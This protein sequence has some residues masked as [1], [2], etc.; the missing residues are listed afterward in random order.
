MR[1]TYEISGSKVHYIDTWTDI[2]I[3]SA[4]VTTFSADG[5]YMRYVLRDV[6]A[7]MLAAARREGRITRRWEYTEDR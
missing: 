6:A 3:D 7:D 1:R 4:V 5:P 2:D